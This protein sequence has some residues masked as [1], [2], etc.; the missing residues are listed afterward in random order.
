MSLTSASANSMG[1]R[2]HIN[3]ETG[4]PGLCHAKVKCRFGGD[5]EHYPS[6]DAAVQAM[7]NKDPELKKLSE[8]S[9]AGISKLKDDYQNHSDSLGEYG[10]NKNDTLF[11][12]GESLFGT[13]ADSVAGGIGGAVIGVT[14]GSLLNL[15][16][17][18]ASLPI[19]LI[20]AGAV[21]VAG[22]LIPSVRTLNNKIKERVMK[23]RLLSTAS[24]VSEKY[25]TLKSRMTEKGFDPELI[26]TQQR[27]VE[28]FSQPKVKNT[29]PGWGERASSE[30]YLKAHGWA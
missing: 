13:V 20:G 29:R 19:F 23:K 7:I 1:A 28:Y 18:V 15:A 22:L 4:K 17:G 6:R 25:D 9:L 26:D 24:Q 11:H 21:T 12:G 30:D 3:P 14:A 27:D 10:V 16:V 2:Y 8:E 5:A